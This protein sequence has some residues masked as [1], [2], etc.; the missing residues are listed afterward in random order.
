VL[1]T[2]PAQL[3]PLS[4][5][6]SIVSSCFLSLGA[7]ARSR[8]GSRSSTGSC[9]KASVPFASTTLAMCSMVSSVINGSPA[10]TRHQDVEVP[11]ELYIP[12]FWTSP[13][14]LCDCVLCSSTEDV[15]YLCPP[16]DLLIDDLMDTKQVV[17]FSRCLVYLD[18]HIVKSLLS[19]S[20]VWM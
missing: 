8:S 7:S 9:Q 11:Y 6:T 19:S 12:L 16:A 1:S 4:N 10:A 15:L 17:N 13:P 18:L 5:H 14:G 20:T 2:Q 3:V